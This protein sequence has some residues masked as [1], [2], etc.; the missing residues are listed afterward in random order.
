M[1]PAT[2]LSRNMKL[3]KKT[4]TMWNNKLILKPKVDDFI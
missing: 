4:L 2:K 1:L 3:P